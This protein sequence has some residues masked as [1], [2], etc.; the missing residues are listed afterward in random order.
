MI[1]IYRRAWVFAWACPLL[2]LL[3]AV[4]EMV[5]HAV[6]LHAGFYDSI[7]AMKAAE[8]SPGRMIAGHFKILALFLTGY[9]AVRFHAFG[10]DPRAARAIDSRAVR[11]FVPVMT[12]G[13]LWL[14]LLQDGPL[15]AAAW[16][17]PAR[18]VGIALLLLFVG[19]M[20][21]EVCLTSWKTAAAVGNDRIGFVRSIA[22]TRGRYWW[23]LGVTLATILPAMIVHYAL[24]VA[25]IGRSPALTWAILFADSLLVA[26]LGA[27][28]ATA[29]Y[30][31]ARRIAERHGLPL[32]PAEPQVPA[33]AAIPAAAR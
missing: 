7:A 16:G 18:A 6:E 4:V 25:A 31:I 5:Q 30:V 27:L 29:T 14:V 9:W 12:W 13:L 24:A 15:L 33:H 10:G 1:E 32:L 22:L 20:A 17:V 3:P 26:A 21:F 28:M 23:A 8:G 2:F 11:L 19:G